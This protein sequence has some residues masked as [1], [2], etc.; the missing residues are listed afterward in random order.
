MACDEVIESEYEIVF[1]P[2]F[3]ATYLRPHQLGPILL[4]WLTIWGGMDGC[5]RITGDSQKKEE[6]LGAT[7]P[8]EYPKF[9]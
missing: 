1:D 3:E 4:R 7:E 6:L 5:V 2:E 8:T 9:A